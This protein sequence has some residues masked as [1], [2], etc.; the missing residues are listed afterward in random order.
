M[1]IR[2]FLLILI[3]SISICL[4]INISCNKNSTEPEEFID[5][6]LR[7]FAGTWNV[8]SWLYKEITTDTSIIP[9]SVDL[10][11]DCNF[12]LTISVELSRDITFKA[13]IGGNDLPAQRGKLIK[14]D[15]DELIISSGSI[16]DTVTYSF[17]EDS[18]RFIYHTISIFNFEDKCNPL[19]LSVADPIH[20]VAANLRVTLQ[21]E[22]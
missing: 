14:K 3:I 11:S 1:S 12:V 4:L 21:K 8:T 22:E 15:E 5:E 16:A 7:P 20:S 6:Q 18:T 9:D 17:L 2:F 13:D 19:N 10:I